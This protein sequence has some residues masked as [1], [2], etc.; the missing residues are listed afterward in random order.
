[1]NLIESC[2]VVS[3]CGGRFFLHNGNFPASSFVGISPEGLK[4]LVAPHTDRIFS[5]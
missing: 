5:G 4:V 1:M 2:V 3:Q